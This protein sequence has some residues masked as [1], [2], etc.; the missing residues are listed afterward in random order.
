MST[1]GA[2]MGGIIVAHTQRQV[3]MGSSNA[4]PRVPGTRVFAAGRG[5][6]A[7][8]MHTFLRTPIARLRLGTK[9]WRHMCNSVDH[10]KVIADADQEGSA[11]GG[12]LFMCA[13]SAGIATIGLL[14]NSPAVIIGAM[15]ISPLMAPIVRL[16]L[17]IGTLDHLRVRDAALVLATGMAVALATAAI[18]VLM[19]PIR[20]I[21]PEIAARTRP[22]L[23]DL[24]VAILSGLAGGYAMVRGRGGAIVG[25]AIATAL[26]PPM[27]VVGYGLASGQWVVMR[28]ALLLFTTNLVAIALSVTAIATWYGF[29]IRKVRHALVWQTALAFLLVLPLCWPLLQS[30]H[31]IERE[32]KVTTSVRGAVSEVF[33]AEGSRVLS[34]KVAT[35]EAR[36]PVHIDLTIAARH[37]DHGDDQKLRAAITKA[38]GKH[39]VLQLSPIIEANPERAALIDLALER[40]AAQAR[41]VPP[42]RVDPVDAALD[43]VPWAMAARRVDVKAHQVHLFM[44]D[45]SLDLAACRALE[46][47]LRARFPRWDITVVPPMRGVPPLSFAGGG[48]T[49]D[50]KATGGLDLAIWALARWRVRDVV[51]YGYASSDGRGNRAMARKRAEVVA[52]RLVAAGLRAE[53]ASAYPQRGQTGAEREAGRDAFR[54]VVI[55]PVWSDASIAPAAAGVPTLPPGAAST[56]TPPAAVP[57]TGQTLH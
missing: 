43:A 53:A 29:S 55:A 34:L 2:R 46:S 11:S 28:G 52:A 7:D 32:A 9:R 3:L 15:L 38:L 21:T 5:L 50:A 20:D 48:S 51:V 19:S 25:V 18:I 47:R 40:Q 39:I 26:M 17:G 56:L 4:R 10:A 22:S 42:P 1:R 31:A 16:G 24:M 49:L 14:L 41:I 6:V 37:Y 54:R 33:G 23:F 27:A 13:M 12:Y 44:A 8:I 36:D 30:L 57:P 45:D 35:G